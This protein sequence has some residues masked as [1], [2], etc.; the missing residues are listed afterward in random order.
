MIRRS[1]FQILDRMKKRFDMLYGPQAT[2]NCLE[3]V[4]MLTGRYGIGLYGED[5]YRYWDQADV[6]LITYADMVSTEDERPIK[7]LHDFL[8]AHLTGAV[9][10]VHLLPF[11]PYSSDDGFSIK[12]YRSVDPVLGRWKDI[13][14]LGKDFSLMFDLVLNHVSRQSE[15]FKHYAQNIAPER[16]YFIE[17]D[18][19]SDLSNVVRPRLQ[20]LLTEVNTKTGVRHLWTTFS[21]DQ[22][23]LNFANP[24]VLF[25]FLDILMQY[26]SHGARVIRLD[27]IAYL[28][29]KVGTNCIHLRETH[30][31]V[32]LIRDFLEM[33]APQVLI[34]SET[35]VPHR[36]NI[37]YFGD[38]DEAQI[39][40]QFSLPPLLLHGLLNEN[41]AQLTRWAAELDRTP[42]GCTYLN[43]AASHDGIGL[44]P[45]EGLVPQKEIDALARHAE[46]LG[47]H[48]ST[49]S[50]PDG[51][52]SPYELNIGF[53]DALGGTE[54]EANAL[55]E[56]RFLCSQ[57]IALELRGLPA[58]YFHS[59]TATPNYEQG[60]A[61]TGRARSI[62]RR[63]W[64]LEELNQL[65]QNKNSTTGRIFNE[66]VRLLRLRAHFKAFHPDGPQEVL[67][68]GPEFFA[69]L[70]TS[71]DGLEKIL[72]ISNFTSTGQSCSIPEKLAVLNETDGLVD[73]IA[74][75]AI[76]D[77]K[78]IPLSPFQTRWI[79]LTPIAN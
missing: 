63:K 59:L 52:E 65:L 47:G 72:A 75:E 26:I 69:V 70:R 7:T 74:D 77:A 2:N 21:P 62:N 35:N 56:Q 42:P 31:V 18:P 3:R 50:N 66:Y 48:V 46:S 4:S 1:S 39:V 20:P 14:R 9:N 5:G 16:N 78:K 71:P 25:E 33:N 61:E 45:L 30:E 79:P 41:A 10:T 53:F 11:F 24:D 27:A 22:I 76:A 49:K 67:D 13:E 58:I 73:R 32:K 19:A 12:D 29:K 64:R 60:V 34:L 36:E 28:W 17:V 55:K 43:F 54:R 6:Y 51:T 37:S 68:L 40:Y 57:I 23:D 8:N 38:G 15:W 44:R